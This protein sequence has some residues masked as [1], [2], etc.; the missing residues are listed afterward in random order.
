[1]KKRNRIFALFLALVML[2]TVTGCRQRIIEDPDADSVIDIST[3]VPS[4]QETPEITPEPTDSP[5][6]EPTAQPEEPEE[7]DDGGE[8]AENGDQKDGI[9]IELDANRGECDV[10]SVTVQKG[11]TYG[12]LPQ[13]YRSGFTFTGWYAAKNGGSAVQSSDIVTESLTLYAHWAAR[14]ESELT[15]DPNGG[16][17]KASETEMPVYVGEAYGD[18]PTPIREGYDFDGWFT[19]QDG[20]EMVEASDIFEGTEDITFYAHW[21]YN[22]FA[23]WTF[24][25]T[26]TTQQIYICQQVSIYLEYDEDNVTTT[27]CSLIS[28]TGSF[29]IAYQ[30]SDTTVT[31]DWVL[32]KKPGCVVKCVGDMSAAAS[33]YSAVA[34]RF[35]GKKIAVV[36]A[37][38]VYGSESQK[39]YYELCLAKFLYAEWYSDVDLEKAGTELGVSG[40]IYTG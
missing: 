4:V 37:E 16:R 34:D 8:A 25:L 26:N 15:L 12:E 17:L 1:M 36:P 32:A 20:G 40:S 38:A 31:D 7:S 18:L 21:T 35:P 28:D 19:E 14:E 2:L 30:V 24:V 11:G 29:N 39:L 9:L 5:E 23:Y 3:P 22:P 10:Q 6:P 27:W 33:Y 13:A